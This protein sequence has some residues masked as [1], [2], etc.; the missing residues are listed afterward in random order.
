M[1]W[2]VHFDLNKFY[3][4]IIRASMPWLDN[5]PIVIL[6]NNDWC[7]ICQTKEAQ[8]LGIQMGTAIFEIEEIIQSCG[9]EVF[10]TN[11]PL[12][13]DMSRRV[14]GI[15]SR[16]FSKLEDYSID[17]VFVEE[18]LALEVVKDKAGK[19]V[20]IIE[21]GLHL[22]ISCGIANTKTLAKVATRFA[23]NYKGYNRICVIATDEQ[24]IKA[25]QLTK[26]E[27][28]WGIGRAHKE[29]LSRKGI[30]TAWQFANG[31]DRINSAWIKKHMTIV[32]FKTYLELNGTP[33]LDL[34]LVIKKK[35]NI[36]VSRG[37][38]NSKIRDYDTIS[39]ALTNYI[40]MNAAKLRAQGSKTKKIYVFLERNTKDPDQNWKHIEIPLPVPT[41]SNRELSDWG[42]VGLKAL[43]QEGAFYRKVGFMTME[44]SDANAVQLNFYDNRDR[45][46]EERL[47]KAWDQII[48]RFGRDAIRTGGQG[49]DDEDWHIRQQKL[50]PCWST[51]Q[52]D[53]IKTTDYPKPIHKANEKIIL[54]AKLTHRCNFQLIVQ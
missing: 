7:S 16:Y 15:L 38:G 40:F 35:K 4:S 37:F 44:I 1:K 12:I 25:L 29:R 3:A 31:V 22:P 18:D 45:K 5:T 46:K 48:A 11:F 24:R 19:V 54:D 42:K 6:S 43:Y 13:A 39:H 17:E 32:G 34:D 52:K 53:F 10:S 23:K 36:M 28:I 9:V 50:A 20:E 47:D 8:A 14:K 26:L 33:C 51:R 2:F 21:Q 41:S 27:D 49:W 30:N